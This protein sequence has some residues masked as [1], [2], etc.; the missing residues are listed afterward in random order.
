M[1]TDPG[2]LGPGSHLRLW[3]NGVRRR[4]MGPPLDHDRHFSG[5]PRALARARLMGAR[6]PYYLL[7]DSREGQLKQAELSQRTEPSKPAHQQDGPRQGF[8]YERVPH[9]MLRSIANN[10]EIDVIW[11]RLPGQTLE[12][13]RDGT[14]HRARTHI[15]RSGRSPARRNRT[16]P[17]KSRDSTPNGGS[18]GSPDRNRS[19][20]PSPPM[21]ISNTS[22]TSPTRTK[23]KVRVAGP[24]TVESLP[25]H[26]IG[27]WESMKTTSSVDTVAESHAAY[28]TASLTTS[29]R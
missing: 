20:H 8:V 19:T 28:G 22:M 7:A 5:R 14:Q 1:A 6:Y 18:S 4:A 26:R 21:P 2:D 16:G 25:P 11:E 29:P 9:I 10:S 3:D 17:L 12:P 24:F 15:G 27:C 23:R 13:L